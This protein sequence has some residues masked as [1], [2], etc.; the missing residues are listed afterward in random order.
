MPPESLHVLRSVRTSHFCQIA[1]IS[2][3]TSL[4]V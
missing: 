4:I 1:G 2:Q 3:H